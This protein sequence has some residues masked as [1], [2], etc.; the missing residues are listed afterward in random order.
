[1]DV[2]TQMRSAAN[3][4]DLLHRVLVHGAGHSKRHV[5]GLRPDRGT[6]YCDDGPVPGLHPLPF[7]QLQIWDGDNNP[8]QPDEAG[9]VVAECEGRCAASSKAG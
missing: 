3:D 2:R 4:N 9:E 5:S 7:A 1:M 6:T 8:V